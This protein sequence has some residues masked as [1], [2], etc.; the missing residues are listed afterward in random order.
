LTSNAIDIDTIY[1]DLRER[2]Q[3]L[4]PLV[5]EYRRLLTASE[6]LKALEAQ[7]APYGYKADG[8]PRKRPGQVATPSDKDAPWG[9]KKDGT[10]KHRP[11][12]RKGQVRADFVPENVTTEQPA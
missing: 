5:E 11:G 7:E 4:Q 3:Q 10:P 9:R 8:T 2:L 6:A 12:R 1:A